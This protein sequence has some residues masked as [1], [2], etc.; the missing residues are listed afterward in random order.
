[1]LHLLVIGP[2][3]EYQQG[4]GPL[5]EQKLRR[6]KKELDLPF[7]NE[8]PDINDRPGAAQSHVVTRLDFFGRYARQQDAHRH[9]SHLV[10]LDAL[11]RDGFQHF[12][13]LHEH[14]IGAGKNDFVK[15]QGRRMATQQV[16]NLLEGRQIC[17]LFLRPVKVSFRIRERH[18]IEKRQPLDLG[19]RQGQQRGKEPVAHLHEVITIDRYQSD[20]SQV[21]E[22]EQAGVEQ[23]ASAARRCGSAEKDAFVIAA[24]DHA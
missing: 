16:G 20:H 24:P 9:G 4:I 8:R 13:A 3:H 1:M 11:G 19:D 2:T 23:L 17:G 21:I 14:M 12:L 6:L 5:V 15:R 7:R 22:K 18:P 10:G